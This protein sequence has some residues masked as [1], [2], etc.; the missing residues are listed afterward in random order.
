MSSREKK[1][2]AEKVE[3]KFD[4]LSSEQ[5]RRKR[6]IAKFN[7]PSDN[8]EL[9]GATNLIASISGPSDVTPSS[10]GRKSNGR[11]RVTR[12]RSKTY[13]YIQKLEYELK[14][15]KM[16]SQKYKRLLMKSKAMCTFTTVDNLTPRSKNTSLLERC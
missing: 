8:S 15:A 3:R 4:T 7:T 13:K 16:S 11:K 1:N 2:T 5:K 10:D 14:V 12:D 9:E 6:I